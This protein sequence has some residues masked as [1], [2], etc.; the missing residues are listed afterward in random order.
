VR[1][2]EATS[3]I[4]Y[5][6]LPITLSASVRRERA[7]PR[8]RCTLAASQLALAPAARRLRMPRRLGLCE[9]GS[10][11]TGVRRHARERGF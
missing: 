1:E 7:R 11:G 8:S 2:L 6:Y 10:A 3:G 9:R 5:S 4:L